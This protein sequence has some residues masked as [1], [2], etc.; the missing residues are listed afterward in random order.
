MKPDTR[1]NLLICAVAII[2]WTI[3]TLVTYTNKP[4]GWQLWVRV[5][6]LWIAISIVV[7]VA[8][9]FVAK[10]ESDMDRADAA[11]RYVVYELGNWYSTRTDLDHLYG[12]KDLRDR[13]GLELTVTQNMDTSELVKPL[14]TMKTMDQ[15]SGEQHAQVLD[16]YL[17]RL[18]NRPA[19]WK[20]YQEYR[21]HQAEISV[22]RTGNK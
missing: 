4:L 11:K 20:K 13:L 6:F 5:G 10:A 18:A 12:Y 22:S 9:L 17:K 8:L 2:G 19:Q 21:K 14:R 1:R 15:L 7:A 16:D 3:T